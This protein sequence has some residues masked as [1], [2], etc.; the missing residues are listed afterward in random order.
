MKGERLAEPLAE[1]TDLITNRQRTGTLAANLAACLN[2]AYAV[3]NLVSADT[4]RVFND[5]GDELAGWR[6]LRP[7]C[8]SCRMRWTGSLPR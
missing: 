7:T 8:S 5:I 6:R 2:A 4:R 3:R 1:I